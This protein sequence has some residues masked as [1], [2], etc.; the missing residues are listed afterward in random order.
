MTGWELLGLLGLMWG[1]VLASVGVLLAYCELVRWRH[2]RRGRQQ[3]LTLAAREWAAGQHGS[4]AHGVVRLDVERAR[5]RP[6][7]VK[8]LDAGP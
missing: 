3:L 4:P 6:E 8:S 7:C 1:G 2:Q 5:R